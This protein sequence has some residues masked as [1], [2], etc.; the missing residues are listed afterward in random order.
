MRG[1]AP[2]PC[3]GA[4]HATNG[5]CWYHF[6]G[7][8][9]FRDRTAA[10]LDGAQQ[11][12][13]R[14]PSP[15]PEGAHRKRPPRARRR[16]WTRPTAMHAYRLRRVGWLSQGA[17]AGRVGR[18]TSAKGNPP[19][20]QRSG[21]AL[22]ALER[23]PRDLP[24]VM[25]APFA[26]LC[27]HRWC[28][29]VR[30]LAARALWLARR[31]ARR[32]CH[33]QIVSARHHYAI[34]FSEA[35]TVTPRTLLGLGVRRLG[36]AWDLFLGFRLIDETWGRGRDVDRQCRRSETE[37]LECF[38]GGL[39]NFACSLLVRGPCWACWRPVGAC[40]TSARACEASKEPLVIAGLFHRL[41]FFYDR[42]SCA[43]RCA[44]QA[45][46]LC[47]CAPGA[48]SPVYALCV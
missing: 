5:R 26:S 35:R 4:S 30:F 3:T 28:G 38:S 44:Q 16:R 23:A 21:P 29:C 12:A 6:D 34:I 20:C 37:P 46:A 18:A 39:P 9:C 10:D 45:A 31:E 1:N 42:E 43:S 41:I 33:C 17:V 47:V 27:G 22:V 13:R 2:T 40:C 24:G 32:R 15:G 19:A 36:C 8:W 25:R 7:V 11:P 14:A 48:C